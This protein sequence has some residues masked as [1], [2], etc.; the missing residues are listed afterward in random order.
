MARAD[1]E[2]YRG[3]LRFLRFEAEAEASRSGAGSEA[4]KAKAQRLDDWLRRI[5]SD[6]KVLGTLAGVQEWAYE[7][8]V[9]DSGQPFKMSIPTDYNPARPSG[10]N[11][12]MHGSG[13][14]HLEHAT[15]M[16]AHEGA[17]ELS[18]LGRARDG[19]F[20]ALSEADVL[21][22]VAYVEAHWAIDPSRVSIRGG[23]MG[24]GGTYRLGSRYPHLW[25][26]ARSS[27]G[28]ASGVPM[29]NLVTLPIYAIHSDDDPVVSVLHERGPLRELRGLGGQV[30]FDETNGYGHAV[31]DYKE[32]AERATAWAKDK[33]RVASRDIRHIDYTA[34]D[35]VAMR[36][37]WGEVAEWGE[38]PREARFVLSA[39]EGNLLYASMTNISRLRLLISESPFDRGRP[40][41][42]SVNGAVPIELPA[43]LPDSAV[44]VRGEN[45][46]GIR[47]WL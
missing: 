44:L 21:Q 2:P 31:W 47:P 4:A 18:V 27:C 29:G 43:P 16:V 11:V 22:A 41:R 9:D 19:G 12:Y 26:S 46:L 6:P 1:L 35:G 20:R 3:W 34:I 17:F 7:S 28:F 30:I 10:L 33:V 23:S 32:G 45:R 25:S 5:T 37:W 15:A 42:V 40:L 39:G 13:G 24:G 36:G 14:N 38:G 8:P